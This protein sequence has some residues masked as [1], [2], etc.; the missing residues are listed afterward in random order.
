MHAFAALFTVQ[1]T[2]KFSWQNDFD[3]VNLNHIPS[4]HPLPYWQRCTRTHPLASAI[5][6]RIIGT[7]HLN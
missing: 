1:Y 3:T 4:P 6:Y 2:N 7:S 5:A